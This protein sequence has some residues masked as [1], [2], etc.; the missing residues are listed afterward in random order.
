MLLS[1][2]K[3]LV[4]LDGSDNSFRA[5]D[6]AIFLAKKLNST[7]TA[8][9]SI[10]LFPSIEVQTIDPI[11]CQVEERKFADV[12]LKKAEFTCER[13][14]IKFT[15]AITHGSPGYAIVKYAKIHKIDLIVIGSRGRSAAKEAFLGSTSNYVLHKSAI[16]VL[17]V[18]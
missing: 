12:V 17:I 8:Q 14:E 4:P 2:K 9:Y 3:I 13:N 6:M 5:L 11:K 16:P 15:K 18:K 1:L 10:S 7:I